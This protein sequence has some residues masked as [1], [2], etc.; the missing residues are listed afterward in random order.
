MQMERRGHVRVGWGALCA[1]EEKAH[2]MREE[3]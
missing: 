3:K 1:G 2:G